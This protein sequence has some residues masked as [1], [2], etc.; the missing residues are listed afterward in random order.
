MPVTAAAV[1]LPPQVGHYAMGGEHAESIEQHPQ[2]KVKPQDLP[3][4][5]EDSDEMCEN[6]A[7]SGEC[8]RNAAFMIGSRARP[9]RCIASCKRCDVVVDT[10]AEGTQVGV[11][12]RVG[13]PRK[14][15]CPCSGSSHAHNYGAP[16]A[17][18][19]CGP[20]IHLVQDQWRKAQNQ[21]TQLGRRSLGGR[22]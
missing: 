12:G 22:A 13:L 6:W 11:L 18:A 5:C 10:G 15:A 16:L 7:E 4:G 3:S 8:E 19:I 14:P 17:H 21:A 20:P 9:G 2:P 1:P